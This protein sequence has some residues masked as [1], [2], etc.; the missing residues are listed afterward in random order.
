MNGGL[1]LNWG[2]PWSWYITLTAMLTTNK[3]VGNRVLTKNSLSD[4]QSSSWPPY[5][6][7]GA[8]DSQASART[9]RAIHSIVSACMY[10]HTHTHTPPT[11]HNDLSSGVDCRIFVFLCFPFLHKMGKGVPHGGGEAYFGLLG[12]K[13]AGIVVTTIRS[14]SKPHFAHQ[15]SLPSVP[16]V[17]L[18][19][20]PPN[21]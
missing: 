3:P 13:K 5:R 15:P 17:P 12:K 8:R 11:E 7:W 1:L 19:Q 9:T 14:S 2:I 4:W 16:H 20:C 10:T 6:R 18:I 21:E